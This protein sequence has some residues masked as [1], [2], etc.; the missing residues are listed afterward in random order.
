MK[1]RAIHIHNFRSVLDVE[2]EA[3]DYMLLVGANNA[4]K[5]TIINALRTFYDDAK[6]SADDFPKA[7]AK[8][9]ESWVQLTFQLDEDEWAALA[10]K[11]KE[12]VINRR[13]KVR[14]YFKSDEKARIQASQSNIFAFVNGQLDTDLFY[15]A[16]NVGAAKLGQVLYVPALTTPAE[17]TKMSGPSPLRNMLNFL[18]KKVV[19]KSEAYKE[20]TTA[21]DKLNVEARKGD[22]FL[23]EISTP[24]NT[25]ISSWSIK[26]DLS[27]N[28]VAPEDISKSLIRF[29]FVDSSLG[30]VG[31][32]LDRYGHGFQR[33]VI[34]ELIRLAP[35]FKD[36]KKADK[37]EFNP[38][39]NLVLFEEPEAFLH[40]SQQESMAYHLRRLG[41]EDGQQVIVTTH[42]PT[43]AGKAA[44]QIGQI[45]RIQR[46]NGATRAFQPKGDTIKDVFDRGGELL[47]ALQAFVAN[48]DV[49]DD[50]KKNA[51][52]MIANPPQGDIATQE[53]QFRFQL[54]LDG[55]RSSLFFADKV[56]LVEGA[57]E[58]G[59]FSYLL[60]NNWHDLSSQRICLVDVLGK[61]NFHR[62]MAL[63]ESY[64][65]PHG[66]MLDD[67][68]G[69][70]HQGA[71]ND[72]VEASVN[73]HTL[74]APV[75][76]PDCLETFLGLPVPTKERKPIEIL[77]AITGGNIAADRLQALRAEFRRSLAI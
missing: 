14:R 39:F 74:A 63:L 3:H 23:S 56:L 62:Y 41:S 50:R 48:P 57:T 15:G 58:R 20:I 53:E 46:S 29:A 44:E 77:K 10:E 26:I 1:L 7:E 22:G 70:E 17:Q 28:S 6:W 60:A 4:G 43:F 73:E 18:L 51:R 24:L 27:V 61:Y 65:I 42:S 21:F 31:F 9:A 40:P 25:A 12:G 8:D 2:I 67:D 52:K 45:V 16:K 64:G 49:P 47:V 71:V 5:S 54:W 72:L 19:A 30:D 69:K 55:E 76:F 13:L 11:Y 75:K 68:N 35:T 32:D 66:V 36:E 34:Y 33:S 59:L 38:A 37:K